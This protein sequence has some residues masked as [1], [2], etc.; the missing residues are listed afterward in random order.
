MYVAIIIY[1]YKLEHENSVNQDSLLE[2]MHRKNIHFKYWSIHC[3]Y[4]FVF[5]HLNLLL[6][7]SDYLSF[8]SHLRLHLPPPKTPTEN[9][10]LWLWPPPCYFHIITPFD[11]LFIC[12]RARP[13]IVAHKL[14]DKRHLFALR[15]HRTYV[16]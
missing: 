8:T 15:R 11:V 4:S 5:E 1:F 2:A 10:R 12:T 9:N 16:Q 14:T 7:S 3:W 6:L 13:Y